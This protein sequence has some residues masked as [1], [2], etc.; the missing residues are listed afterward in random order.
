MATYIGY[1]HTHPDFARQQG[2]KARGGESAADPAFQ[3]KVI[4]LRDNLPG[5]LKL[6]GS[7]GS[8]SSQTPEANRER[9]NLWICETDDTADLQFISNYYA[10]Y[11]VF[12]WVPGFVIGATAS[13]T[14]AALETASQN[15]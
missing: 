6:I 2:E 13:E 7:F 4:E 14:R 1:Y 3:Q 8:M 5:S 10:G 15:R 9:P 12:E 11:L